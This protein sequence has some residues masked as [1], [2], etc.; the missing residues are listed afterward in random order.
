MG[1]IVAGLVGVGV[2]RQHEECS[3]I[4][5]AEHGSQS[6]CP[7]GAATRWVMPP[8]RSARRNSPAKRAADHTPRQSQGISV[9]PWDLCR[10]VSFVES[11]PSLATVKAIT[12]C[13]SFTRK[14][15]A[16]VGK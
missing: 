5:S 1:V 13:V 12:R 6:Q 14:Q 2:S 11:V 9:G 4:W 15:C 8:P 3:P 16:A 10:E 7:L